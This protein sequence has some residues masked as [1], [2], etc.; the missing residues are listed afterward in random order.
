MTACD[1]SVSPAQAI[2]T[3]DAKYEVLMGFSF[4]CRF[5][6]L[7]FFTCIQLTLVL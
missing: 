1:P 5:E 4:C 2:S 7:L 6:T 3:A